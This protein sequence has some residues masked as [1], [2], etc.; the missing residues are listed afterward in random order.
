MRIIISPYHLTSRE[1]PAMGALLLATEAMTLAPEPSG[2][3]AEDR[4]LAAGAPA[5]LAFMESWQWSV[6]LWKA[7]VLTSHD[8]ELAPSE[9]LGA[10]VNLLEDDPSLAPVRRFVHETLSETGDRAHERIARDILRGGPDPAVSIP[11]HAAIDAFAARTGVIVARAEPVSMAQRAEGALARK[12][13]A[14]A[15]PMV[16]QSSA[17][18]LLEAR[19]LLAGA[20]D[21]L[22]HALCEAC[23]QPAPM[24]SSGSSGAADPSPARASLAAAAAR[25]TA[26]FEGARERLLRSE[27]DEDIR[28]I[29]ALCSVTIAD[30][31]A[32]ATLRSSAMAAGAA[33]GP[34]AKARQVTAIAPAPARASFLT[35]IVR[36]IGRGRR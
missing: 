12:R 28:V 1:P 19:E 8:G 29:D 7:G 21:E 13:C 30:L 25:Y 32:D 35:M 18:R 15:I 10:A 23:D 16:L 6:P 17:Q 2:Q 26:E 5:F 34:R 27:D 11:V 36:P 3:D 33:G 20:L 22:R 9:L 14:V 24:A 4:R 31:P